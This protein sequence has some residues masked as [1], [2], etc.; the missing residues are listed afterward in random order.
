MEQA[1]L[2]WRLRVKIDVWSKGLEESLRAINRD[3]L[4]ETY[5]QF[6]RRRVWFYLKVR[7]R[8]VLGSEQQCLMHDPEDT[9]AKGTYFIQNYGSFVQ[10]ELILLRSAH[11]IVKHGSLNRLMYISARNDIEVKSFPEFDSWNSVLLGRNRH[12]SALRLSFLAVQG[13]QHVSA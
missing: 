5:L 11:S 7:R 12:E 2:M 13:K 9:I 3:H 10:D 4:I 8:E 6:P 1:E